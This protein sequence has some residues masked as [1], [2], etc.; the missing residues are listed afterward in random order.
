MGKS[1][2]LN[3]WG[4]LLWYECTKSV[5]YYSD[6][7]RF[8]PHRSFGHPTVSSLYKIFKRSNPNDI[9]IDTYSALKELTKSSKVCSG[10][11]SQPKWFRL[12]LGE[13]EISFNDMVTA[14]IIN[15]FNVY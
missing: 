9:N 7:A 4:G 2:K 11:P 6:R 13:Q 14:D 1:E 5:S 15:V 8:R 3:L 12:T 10:H